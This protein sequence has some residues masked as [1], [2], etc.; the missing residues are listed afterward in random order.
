MDLKSR[1]LSFRGRLRKEPA[2]AA[3]ELE[4]FDGTDLDVQE[5][6][7]TA[8]DW[9]EASRFHLLRGRDGKMETEPRL[10]N[11][12]AR[13]LVLSLCHR[14]G[15][16]LFPLD[17]RAEPLGMKRQVEQYAAAL[18]ELP[19]IV[20]DRWYEQAERLSGLDAVS[21]EALRKNFNGQAPAASPSASL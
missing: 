10:D 2:A 5:L 20:L 13:L 16:M 18:G 8:R 1:L 19:A 15:E 12:R 6:C 3:P 14:S 17:W 11:I 9:Y 7:A 21:D 4:G